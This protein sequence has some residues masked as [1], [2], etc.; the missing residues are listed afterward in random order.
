[1]PGTD[2]DTKHSA[3]LVIPGHGCVNKIGTGSLPGEEELCVF[4]VGSQPLRSLLFHS[5]GYLCLKLLS[6]V[7]MSPS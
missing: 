1:V 4:T 5:I 6:C 3:C 7:E 2:N